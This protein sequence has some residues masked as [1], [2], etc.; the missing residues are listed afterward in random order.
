MASQD[1]RHIKENVMWRGK[2]KKTVNVVVYQT[3]IDDRN[4]D[5]TFFGSNGVYYEV[6]SPP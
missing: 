2:W 4:N 6:V 1:R 5:Q 3:Q